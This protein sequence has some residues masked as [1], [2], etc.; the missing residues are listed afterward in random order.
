MAIS[1]ALMNPSCGE[2]HDRYGIT[3]FSELGKGH[4]VWEPELE[5]STLQDY[6]SWLQKRG[7]TVT[8]IPRRDLNLNV[9]GVPRGVKILWIKER[10]FVGH[11]EFVKC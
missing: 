2:K 6:V 11:L 4:Y 8:I 7:N 9:Q 10:D 5:F 1:V 3:E